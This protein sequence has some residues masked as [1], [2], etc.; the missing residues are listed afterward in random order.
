MRI[1]I[2]EDATKVPE[3]KADKIRLAKLTSGENL[4][5]IVEVNDEDTLINMVSSFCWSPSLFRGNRSNENFMSTDFIV[6]DIDE[7]LS[8]LESEVRIKSVNLACLCLPSP[9][10]TPENQ[11]HRL[12]F[13]LAKTIS[14]APDFDS[15]LSYMFSIFPESDPN[16]IDP[17]RW[18]CMSKLGDGFW[19]DGL[20]L[21]P[22][23]AKAPDQDLAVIN[24]NLVE[25]PE[26]LKEI[27][28]LLYGKERDKFPEAVEFFLSNAY[29]GLSGLWVSS[30][31]AF[32]FSLA[33]SGVEESLVWQVLEEIAPQDLDRTDKYQITRAL[34]DGKKKKLQEF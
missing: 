31:N 29:T 2:W 23:K 8:I 27:V 14:N 30:L 25:V 28:T 20:F 33:L 7:G 22:V 18:F 17:A 19:Q 3:N 15:T 13:P 24:Q 10:F 9:S 26:D 16:C 5:S 12:I 6:L 11:K 21:L 32:C 34:R 4:P 1:S